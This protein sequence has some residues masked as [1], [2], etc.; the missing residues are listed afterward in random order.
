MAEDDQKRTER[1]EK[2]RETG[3]KERDEGA[4][5]GFKGVEVE[6]DEDDEGKERVESQRGGHGHRRR[7]AQ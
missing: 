4:E 5:A 6:N 7:Y 2:E 3:K 1:R